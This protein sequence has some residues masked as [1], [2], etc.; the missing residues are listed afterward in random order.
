MPAFLLA[1]SLVTAAPAQAGLTFNFTFDPSLN[2]TNFGSAANVL[3]L[4]N[5]VIAVGNIFSGFF[6]NNV[7]LKFL[8]KAETTAGALAASLATYDQ[9]AAAVYNYT[10]LR[11]ALEGNPSFP[12]AGI[13]PLAPPTTSAS[14]GKY[15]MPSAEAKAL[16]LTA[17]A[18][19]SDGTF[20]VGS[21]IGGGSHW[22]FNGT[23]TLAP[24]DYS[25]VDAAEHEISELMGRTAQLTNAT[26]PWNG[27]MDLFRCTRTSPTTGVINE[28]PTATGV[29]FSTDGCATDKK[30]YNAPGGAADI[31]DWANSATPDPYDAFATPGAYTAL[32][33]ADQQILNAL[34]WTSA[35]TTVP[36]PMSLAILAPGLLGLFGRRRR[37]T[38]G[39]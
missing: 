36:E 35:L 7:M 9:V 15:I 21:N 6:T 10:Q 18:A 5:D 2:A 20:F 19:V 37:G 16:G 39:G 17:D 23:S 4:E 12:F 24:S 22:D 3:S 32:S 38:T 34:G 13:L 11:T 29:Y 33:V 27:P 28:S 14:S 31:Q 25:F 26:W 30:D 1:G 8:V